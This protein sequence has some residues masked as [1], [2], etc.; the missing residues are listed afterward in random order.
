[1]T[2]K[3]FFSFKKNRFFWGNLL[4]VI[5]IA[6]LLVFIVLKAL[7]SY[8]RHGQAIVVPDAKGLTVSEAKVLFRGKGLHCAISDSTYVKDKP[9]GSILEHTPSS[10]QRVKEGRTIYLTI[11]TLSVPLQI[12]PD[13]A[14]NSSL[15]QAQARILAAGFKLSNNESTRGEKDWVYKVKY[16]GKVL[17]SSDK[18]PVGA[19]LTLVV[20]DGAGEVFESDSTRNAPADSV[21][22]ESWF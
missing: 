12:V 14:D 2:I 20:G 4:A 22:D 17:G 21:A 9:A 11:N 6:C 3:E 15:R 1:M 18:V 10:G 5:I 7:D 8:T 19:T 16:K 13:V